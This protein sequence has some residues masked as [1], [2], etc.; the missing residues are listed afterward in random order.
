MN[1]VLNDNGIEA[2]PALTGS[3][4]KGILA[5]LAASAA[6][7]PLLA[8]SFFIALFMRRSLLSKLFGRSVQSSE[9]RHDGGTGFAADLVLAVATGLFGAGLAAMLV[10]ML[11]K[12]VRRSAFTSVGAAGYAVL[13]AAFLSWLHKNLPASDTSW[14]LYVS[15][16]WIGAFFALYAV[17][18]IQNEA[19]L[20]ADTAPHSGTA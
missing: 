2:P 13:A 4:P 5:G 3:I 19:A 10:L 17:V 18:S 15:L 12:D 20:E 9:I 14:G 8:I 11:I 6:G 7:I 1:D 16:G